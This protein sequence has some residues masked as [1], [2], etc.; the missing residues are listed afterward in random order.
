MKKRQT[1]RMN[2]L[3]LSALALVALGA[4]SVSCQKGTYL[5]IV[6]QGQGLPPDHSINLTITRNSDAY[7]ASGVLP[8][9]PSAGS[10]ITF[11]VSVVF[12]LNDVAGDVTVA[13]DALD[14]AGAP[15]RHAMV[16]TTVMPNKTWTVVLDFSDAGLDA[17]ADDGSSPLDASD[18]GR[19]LVKI[20]DG[21]VAEGAAGCVA[22]TVLAS[23]SVSVDYNN[24]GGNMDAGNMLWASLGPQERFIGWAKF[25]LRFIPNN[26]GSFRI[27]KATLNL[28]LSQGMAGAAPQL[29]VRS[30]KDDGWTRSSSADMIS[31]GDKMSQVSV[32]PPVAVPAVNAYALD[33]T[34]HDW[35]SDIVDG[36]ITLGIENVTSLT[37]T[38]TTS[39]AEFYGV[40]PPIATD[41]TRPTLDLEFCR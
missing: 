40:T 22:A 13:A 39:K 29:Q 41:T 35:A 18:D 3:W 30:S 32:L 5:E 12:R 7:Y 1:S 19:A 33:V 6:F 34:N 2:T 14:P 4:V 38:I 10:V 24:A 36:T 20:T 26:A 11:P 31:I 37:T 21:S 27:S 16:M 8:D 28:S 15:I 25:G 17:G 9:S 23:E